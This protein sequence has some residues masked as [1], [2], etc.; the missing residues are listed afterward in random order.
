MSEEQST[1]DSS[2]LTVKGVII[3]FFRLKHWISRYLTAG[4]FLIDKNVILPSKNT[5]FKYG[6][7]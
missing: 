6:R 1:A 2:P 3:K 5:N 4:K 7:K